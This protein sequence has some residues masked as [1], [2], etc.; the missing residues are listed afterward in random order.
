M[1]WL[2]LAVAVLA[3]AA[4]GGSDSA[5]V[6]TIT[7]TGTETE[8]TATETSETTPTT[9]EEA[10]AL[11]PAFDVPASAEVEAYRRASL[12]AF[13]DGCITATWGAKKATFEKAN[14]KVLDGLAAFP[15]ATFVS[16]Y[17]IDHRDGNGCLEG[18]GPPTSYAT[19]RNYRLPAGTPAKKVIDFYRPQ[20]SKSGFVPSGYTACEQTFTRGEAYVYLS[21]CNDSL[22]VSAKALPRVEPPPPPTIPPRPYGA[23]YPVARGY[24]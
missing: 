9:A 24:G 17:S 12:E 20:L 8:S 22:R 5:D 1:R 6:A 13:F 10:L 3:L 14:R 23:Q 4:C 19:D 21:A 16:E 7:T 2:A 15:G 11:L 18:S